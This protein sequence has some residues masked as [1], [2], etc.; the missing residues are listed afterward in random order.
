MELLMDNNLPTSNLLHAFGL[1]FTI[2]LILDIIV[3]KFFGFEVG[4][5]FAIA[6]STGSI[7]FALVGI[8]NVIILK[9]KQSR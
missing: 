9:D 2:N 8:E 6:L 3:Y 7:G 5:I 4:L 1:F